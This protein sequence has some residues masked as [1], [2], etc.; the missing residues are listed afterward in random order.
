MINMPKWIAIIVQLGLAGAWMMSGI[1]YVA[2]PQAMERVLGM[3]DDVRIALGVAM[4]LL[5]ILLIAGIFARPYGAL[6][7]G[8]LIAASIA[9]LLWVVYDVARAWEMFALFHGVLAVFAAGLAWIR[10]RS[11]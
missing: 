2:T 1:V 7:K 9:A 3:S 6:A 5:A 4:V 8:A 11:G 10:A